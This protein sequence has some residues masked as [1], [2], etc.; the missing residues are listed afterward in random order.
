MQPL[1]AVCFKNIIL[2]PSCPILQALVPYSREALLGDCMEATS[3]AEATEQLMTKT[4]PGILLG[5]QEL[6]IEFAWL[7]ECLVA[8]I[9][10]EHGKI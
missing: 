10:S 6:A 2:L 3:E 1:G 5:L 9:V 4:T 7:P 8:H